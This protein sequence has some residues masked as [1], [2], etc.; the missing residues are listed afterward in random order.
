MWK[1]LIFC[2]L[3]V[4]ELHICRLRSKC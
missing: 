4:L 2:R 1:K 3:V